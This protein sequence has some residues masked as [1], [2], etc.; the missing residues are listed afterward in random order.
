LQISFL[1]LHFCFVTKEKLL[2]ALLY[3]KFLRKMLMKLTLVV[4]NQLQNSISFRTP[5]LKFLL[6]LKYIELLSNNAN[7]LLSLNNGNTLPLSLVHLHNQLYLKNKYVFFISF[8]ELFFS[9]RSVSSYLPTC[10]IL[11]NPI[12]TC[13]SSLHN[14]SGKKLKIKVKIIKLIK[15][16]VF[17]D[18]DS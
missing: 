17:S 15:H 9:D 2:K 8:S 12:C 13:V 5:L 10:F 11:R 3:K 1:Y 4:R 7:T 16:R 14:F 6:G 18:Y